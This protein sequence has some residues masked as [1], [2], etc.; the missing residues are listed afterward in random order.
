MEFVW[1]ELICC[2]SK[3]TT[4][5]AV[6]FDMDGVLIDA[7]EWHYQALNA[8]LDIFGFKINEEEHLERFDGLPTKAKLA[9]LSNER[10]LPEHLH[11][12]I[13]AVKQERTL[14][15]AAINCY[16]KPNLLSIMNY[17]KVTGYSIGLATNSIRL[18]TET[19]MRYAGLLDYFDVILTN[20]DV[21]HPK[22]NPEIYLKGAQYFNLQTSEVVVFEDNHHGLE[23]ARQAGCFVF[24]VVSPDEL[25]LDHVISTLEAK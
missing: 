6:I 1:I 9:I 24:E 16:P 19:M 5:K 4:K 12:T 14:R 23:A 13:N 25:F 18:T 20:E 10:G 2:M 22:P 3:L 7:K 11:S 8:A 21:K 17:L 15:L